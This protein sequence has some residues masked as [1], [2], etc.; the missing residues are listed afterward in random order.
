MSVFSCSEFFW[1]VFSRILIE[2]RISPYSVGMPENTD[3]EN[4]EYGHISRSDSWW[5]IKS[6]KSSFNPI[7]PELK[8]DGGG[9]GQN[10][11]PRG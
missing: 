10:N 7:W 1:Y 5:A 6:N 9:G 11:P 4:F 8:G 2:L 3:Q